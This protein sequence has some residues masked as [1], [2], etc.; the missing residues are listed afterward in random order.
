MPMH[1]SYTV[2]QLQRVRL[3]L[4]EALGRLVGSNT[5]D[6]EAD[7]LREGAALADSD[8]VTLGD[9]ERR[10]NVR[11]K[12]LVALLV[13]AVLGD[14]VEVL[15][16]DDEGVGHLGGL[17]NT[18]EDTATDGDIASEGALLVNVGAVDGLCDG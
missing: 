5:E 2:S 6:V 3:E 7:S 15:A 16:T 13:S 1:Q 10:G 9:T 17:H 14:E 12:V 11:G 18:G 8:G 4:G